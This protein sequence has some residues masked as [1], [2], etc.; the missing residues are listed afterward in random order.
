MA[1][2]PIKDTGIRGFLKWFKTQQPDLY[3]KIAP[4]LPQ[5]V[6]AAFSGYH[7]GG[8][9]TAGLSRDAAVEKLNGM[10][11]IYRGSFNNRVGVSGL[12]DYSSY[13]A[14][15]GNYYTSPGISTNVAAY[16]SMPT[17]NIPSSGSAVDVSDAA[18]NGVSASTIA[19]AIG[20]VVNSASQAYLTVQQANTQANLINT[21]LARAAAGLTPLTTSL[22]S[23]G[24]PTVT[25]PGLG[26]VSSGG[27]LLVG[28]AALLL[29]LMTSK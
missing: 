16:A 11:A 13:F 6:P 3:K 22:S 9:K 4:Q 27:L 18:N 28:G 23:V 7:N 21:Q 2:T 10:A 15:G 26:S 29:L 25:I 24:V 12:S 5:Q 1:T 8:W 19:N 20:T 17:A 14:S